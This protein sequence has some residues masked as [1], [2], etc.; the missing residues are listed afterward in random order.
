MD[1]WI[2][3]SVNAIHRDLAIQI[4]QT[5]AFCFQGHDILMH[6]LGTH[7]GQSTLG[8]KEWNP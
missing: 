6:A 3:D 4:V 8:Y 2:D 7:D 1:E 5:H